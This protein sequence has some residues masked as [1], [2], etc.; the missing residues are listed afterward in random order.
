MQQILKD[1]SI[2]VVNSLID[3]LSPINQDELHKTLNAASVLNEF[4]DNE[5]F[6]QLLIEPQVL[7]RIVNATT[8]QDSNA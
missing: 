4:C 1:K 8:S 7:R 3:K 5:T 6:F 2:M